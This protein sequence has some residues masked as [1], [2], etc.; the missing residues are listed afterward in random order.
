[1]TELSESQKEVLN[2]LNPNDAKDIAVA[3]RRVF[4]LALFANDDTL[5]SKQKDDLYYLEKIITL[6]QNLK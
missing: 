5:T 3:L 1:M 4:N 6:S 2:F